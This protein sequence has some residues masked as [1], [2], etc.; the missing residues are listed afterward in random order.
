MVCKINYC[1]RS[2]PVGIAVDEVK[3]ATQPYVP[4]TVVD[5]RVRRFTVGILTTYVIILLYSIYIERRIVVLH[6][7]V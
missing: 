2:S 6:K 4:R 3:V 7:R 1:R 5:A